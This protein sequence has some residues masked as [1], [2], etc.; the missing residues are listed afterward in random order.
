[1]IEAIDTLERAFA[2]KKSFTVVAYVDTVGLTQSESG[3]ETVR[4]F[5]RHP[6]ARFFL[7]RPNAG[8]EFNGLEVRDYMAEHVDDPKID[9]WL[10]DQNIVSGTELQG[11]V[12]KFTE[13]C[14]TREHWRNH[15]K[16]I[17]AQMWQNFSPIQ[18]YKDDFELFLQTYEHRYRMYEAWV[19]Q[20]LRELGIDTDDPTKVAWFPMIWRSKKYNT[21][22]DRMYEDVERVQRDAKEVRQFPL[23]LLDPLTRRVSYTAE[24]ILEALGRPR[25]V[26]NGVIYEE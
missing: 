7:P 1:M 9:E 6:R 16:D 3:T 14:G 22:F 11:R 8:I 13:S 19:P 15:W 21:H 18:E 12:T 2:H 24:E 17:Y 23:Q 4:H 26:T 20:R 25:K 10:Q 5:A